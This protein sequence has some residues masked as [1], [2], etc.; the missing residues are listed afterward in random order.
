MCM[1]IRGDLEGILGAQ[2][3]ATWEGG[4]RS[5]CAAWPPLE[6][7][8]ESFFE[9]FENTRDLLNAALP[10]DLQHAVLRWGRRIEERFARPPPPPFVF[11]LCES[12]FGF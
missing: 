11:D 10:R 9:I 4:R 5:A 12:A 6:T 2:E 7:F 3:G 1:H 8:F